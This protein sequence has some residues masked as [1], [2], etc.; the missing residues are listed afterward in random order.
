MVSKR[1]SGVSRIIGSGLP[2]VL[3]N[4]HKRAVV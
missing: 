1:P 3:A 2:E 4:P